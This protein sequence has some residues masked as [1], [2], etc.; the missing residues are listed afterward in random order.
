MEAGHV[1]AS[2]ETLEAALGALIAE[3]ALPPQRFDA[4][5]A[6]ATARRIAHLRST[7]P[8][9]SWVAVDQGEVIGLAQSIRRDACWVLVH[10]FIRPGSQSR[11]VGGALL[12]RARAYAAD[13]PVG[14]IGATP[15]P[16]AI[17]TYA[18][19]DGFRV[20]PTLAA[21]GVVRPDGLDARR[22][23]GVRDGTT[24]DLELAA[25]LDRRRRGGAHGPDLAFLL[26]QGWSLRVVPGRGYAASGPNLALLATEDEEAAESLLVDALLR[27]AG[28][29]PVQL[30]RMTAEQ[31]WAHG[32]VLD[33]GLSLRPW[34]PLV[35][36]GL[37]AAPAPY[38]PHPSMC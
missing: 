19:M 3:M 5:T 26:T 4:V 2:A 16:R 37:D 14:L 34:G 10:L 17:R 1:D 24:A 32:I 12:A 29:A 30:P 31:H 36:R 38:L 8:D 23:S 7:D 11:G 27:V 13:A 35:V 25:D 28:T 9:G 33:A 6:A 20:V 18:H 22:A 21:F 15:D